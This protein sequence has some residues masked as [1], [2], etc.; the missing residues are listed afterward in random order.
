M[1]RSS[2]PLDAS[3]SRA[4]TRAIDPAMSRLLGSA[5]FVLVAV[6]I[7]AHVLYLGP[8]RDAAE[9]TV[10]WL[11]W[12]AAA[13]GLIAAL[14]LL[15]VALLLGRASPAWLRFVRLSRTLGAVLGSALIIVGM[16]HYRDTQPTG[17]IQ[18]LVLGLAILIAT[19]IV[20]A[21]LLLTTRKLS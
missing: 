17:D 20:Q 9:F 12:A 6:W 16:L 15:A 11:V 7:V 2:T 4:S 5:A 21:W 14:T 10:T 18:W 13:S 8:I 19:G 1:G 3:R